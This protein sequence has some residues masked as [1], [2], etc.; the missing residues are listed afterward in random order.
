[1]VGEI[2][3]IIAGVMLVRGYVKVGEREGKGERFPCLYETRMM[4]GWALD[5]RSAAVKKKSPKQRFTL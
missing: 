5:G 3:D 4:P 2:E 1:L